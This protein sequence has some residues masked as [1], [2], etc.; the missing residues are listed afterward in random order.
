MEYFQKDIETISRDKLLALQ[1]TRLITSLKAA[2][3]T[4]FYAKKY[5]DSG[6]STGD[7]TTIDA[8]RKLPFTTKDDLRLSYPNGMCA[9]P[10]EDI[11]RMHASSGTTGKPTVIFH[12]AHDIDVWT[13]LVA[14]SLFMAGMRKRDVFQNMM[15]YGLFTGGLGLH[16]GAERLGMMVIPASS[17]NTKRQIDLMTDFHTTAMH[18]TPSYALHFAEEVVAHGFDPKDLGLKFAVM[19]AEPYSLATAKKIEAAFGVQVF[20][21]YGLSEMNGPA[22]AFECPVKNGMHIWEDSYFVEIINPETLKPANPGEKGELVLTTIN[23]TAMPIIRYR[24]KDLTMLYEETCACGRTHK[25]I[26]RILGRTDDMLIISG[27]NVFPS[28]IE[29]VLMEIPEVGNNYQIVLT[30]E[31]HLDKMLVKVELYEKIFKGDLSQLHTIQ[32][33]IEHELK[34]ALLI[35]PRV[36]LTEPGEIPPSTGKAKRVDDQRG[37]F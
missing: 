25:R 12:S 13:D 29:H 33:K 28:Q 17:G 36:K 26:E 32:K 21:C 5:A 14:R 3:N 11:V 9:I 30:R 7:I 18:I 4:P 22:V 31:G 15:T 1:E 6:V 19:G 23:R 35:S 37:S 27:V 10:D 34:S 16:Y 8:F 24:T 2:A 20:N